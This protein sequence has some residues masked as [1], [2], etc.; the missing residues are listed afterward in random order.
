L[1]NFNKEL[2]E[3]HI[4]DMFKTLNVKEY[5]NEKIDEILK[6]LISIIPNNGKLYKYRLL[7]GE[8]FNYNYKAL[9]EK[10]IYLPEAKI[11]NDDDDTNLN[12][13]LEKEIEDMKNWLMTSPKEFLQIFSKCE[14]Q[15]E[16]L[17]I[18]LI[19]LKNQNLTDEE[20][21]NYILNSSKSEEDVIKKYKLY[22]KIELLVNFFA[23][24]FKKENKSQFLCGYHK[25][26]NKLRV[27][28]MTESYDNNQMWAYYSNKIGFCIEY[29][30]NKI[31]N[32]DYDTKRKLIYTFKIDYKEKEIFSL[33][34]TLKAKHYNDYELRMEENKKANLQIL[35]KDEGWSNEKEWRIISELEVPEL[36]VDF[37]SAIIIDERGLKIYKDNCDK[38]IELAKKNNWKIIIRKTNDYY[39]HYYE[40]YI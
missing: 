28:S 33:I 37:V 30:Y 36:Y 1:N 27:F 7:E 21:Y 23:E 4:N 3:E 22:H 34:P 31:M 17:L 16:E 8:S 5:S 19:N 40:E 20:I 2:Y 32:M 24:Y 35:T 9:K 13:N 18:E 10:Y 15:N 39:K 29:D 26:K 6:R 25:I 12:I 38:L 14:K 11:L